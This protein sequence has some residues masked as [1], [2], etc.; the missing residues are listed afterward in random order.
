MADIKLKDG[1]GSGVSYTG[2]SKLKIPAAD[3]GDDVVFQLPPVMQEKAVTITE[4]GTTEVTPDEG[5]D[6]LSKVTVETT[7]PVPDTQEKSVTI[8]ENGTSS[9]T[10]DEGKVLSKVDVT[11]DVAG[12]APKLQ[13]KTETY[14]PNSDGVELHYDIEPDSGYDGLSKVEVTVGGYVLPIIQP[15]RGYG[16]ITENG[17]YSI[18]PDEAGAEAMGMVSFT[19]DVPQSSG[20]GGRVV[21]PLSETEN[22]RVPSASL[23]ILS[24]ETQTETELREATEKATEYI[25]IQA[26]IESLG[27]WGPIVVYG[28]LDS[29]QLLKMSG[30]EG[31]VVYSFVGGSSQ[32]D[33]V[34]STTAVITPAVLSDI[35]GKITAFIRQAF[36]SDTL[37]ITYSNPVHVLMTFI[38]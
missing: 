17:E 24:N 36:G 20:G 3:G 38:G 37:E 28:D 27:F 29:T 2:V 10:P 9:V 16:T 14:Y 21:T 23:I 18:G 22:V 4:N 31:K 33:A 8:T 6:G 30:T 13:E 7:V 12:G 5:K 35:E 15:T 34:D 19:V 26:T 32:A 11:V 25:V 1:T